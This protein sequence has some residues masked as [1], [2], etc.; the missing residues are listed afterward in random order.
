MYEMNDQYVSKFLYK[1]SIPEKDGW[2][3][4]SSFHLFS[5]NLVSF[6]Y[7]KNTLKLF[8]SFFKE[9][10]KRNFLYTTYELLNGDENHVVPGFILFLI[11][12]VSVY[13]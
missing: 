7:I 8:I 5:V 12:G 6:D 2:E 13:L 1:T 3:F 10:N 9:N 4:H 11:S